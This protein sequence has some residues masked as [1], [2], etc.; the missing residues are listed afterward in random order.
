TARRW[1]IK[2]G[3]RYSVVQK[4]V[5]ID[6]HERED[7]VDYHQKEFLL[8]MVGYKLQMTH[9]EGPELLKVEPQLKEGKKSIIPYFY[10][11]CCF[12]VND[13]WRSCGCLIHISNFINSETGCLILTDKDG[14]IVKDARKIVYLGSNGDL[15]WD[16]EQLLVH[17]KS[18]IKIHK[19]AHSGIQALFIFDQLSAHASLPP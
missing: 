18:T 7:I 12:N 9:Y 16:N 11:E 3:W 5:Y 8:T 10:D 15:W 13:E 17:I 19:E 4:G 6:G 1:L 14:N 2:L